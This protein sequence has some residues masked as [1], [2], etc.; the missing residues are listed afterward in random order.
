[1]CGTEIFWG[2][3]RFEDAMEWAKSRQR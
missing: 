3:D 1:V 2:D